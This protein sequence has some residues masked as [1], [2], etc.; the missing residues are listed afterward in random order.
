[1]RNNQKENRSNEDYYEFDLKKLVNILLHEKKL[2]IKIS[3][4]FLF[5][6]LVIAVFSKNFY[7]SQTTFVPQLNSNL[8]SSNNLSGLASLAGINL[9]S[10]QGEINPDV[11]PEI[12]NSIPFK[13]D[14][15]E[16]KIFFE[17]D[18]INYRNYLQIKN[19][20]FSLVRTLKKYTLGLPSL[21][22]SKLKTKGDLTFTNAQN[23][24][25][26][27]NEEDFKLFKL[28]NSALKIELFPKEGY[29][30]LSYTDNNPYISAQ[31]AFNAQDILQQKIISYKSQSANEF[32]K[33]SNN[34]YNLKK[35]ENITLQDKIGLFKDQNFGISRSLYQ[36]KLDRLESELSIS[37][38]VLQQ[39]ANQVEQAK[40]Q[41]SKDTPVFSIIQPVF[42]PNEKSGPKRSL[43]VLSSGFLGIFFSILFIVFKQDLVSFFKNLRE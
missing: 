18:S 35:Q 4:I 8:K 24:M 29:I 41:V 5:V 15:L 43:I 1:M 16:S 23:K 31:V 11:Y 12:I 9:S 10:N 25:F 20:K 13:I 34:Q 33:Y 7:T 30:K 40:L 3:L 37:N 28:V 14:L 19:R 21:I 42:V 22:L 6:G 26:F 36:N 38:S 32:L 39:L 2:F 17:N 27:I